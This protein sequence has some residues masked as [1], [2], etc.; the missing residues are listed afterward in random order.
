MEGKGNG[1]D[2]QCAAKVVKSWLDAGPERLGA[3]SFW[4][5]TR[6]CGAA[7]PD[8]ERVKF[9]CNVD[10]QIFGAF[11]GLRG[12]DRATAINAVGSKCFVRLHNILD[13]DMP[14]DLASPFAS[15]VAPAPVLAGTVLQPRV[16]SYVDGVPVTRQDAI[17]VEPPLEDF[18]WQKSMGTSDVAS[19]LAEEQGKSLV[20]GALHRPASTINELRRVHIWGTLFY[21]WLRR[22]EL[23][24][25]LFVVVD[26]VVVDSN[27]VSSHRAGVATIGT[28]RHLRSV[29][30][31]TLQLSISEINYCCPWVASRSVMLCTE[32]HQRPSGT[33]LYNCCSLGE[34][35]VGSG[36][37]HG[38]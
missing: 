26:V 2:L 29:R 3:K 33:K 34:C 37:R 10:V 1:L 7:L 4:H 20:F 19:A 23:P 24:N 15:V 30:H 27:T 5:C 14:G 31:Q 9:F 21:L 12:D 11:L 18:L 8:A 6:A 13:T 32:R 22:V 35:N 16:I 38:L 17:D 25:N 28:G 36:W